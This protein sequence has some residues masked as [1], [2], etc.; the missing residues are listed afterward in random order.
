M[1]GHER[2]CEHV[3][4]VDGFISLLVRSLLLSHACPAFP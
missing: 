1:T 3:I 2:G 4:P